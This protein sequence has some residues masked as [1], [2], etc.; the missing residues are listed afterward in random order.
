MGYN[1][2]AARATVP[3]TP[4]V[5]IPALAPAS[6]RSTCSG[7]ALDSTRV[8][9]NQFKWQ[10]AHAVT[11]HRPAHPGDRRPNRPLTWAKL[12][13]KR[14]ANSGPTSPASQSPDDY[15]RFTLVGNDW[16]GLLAWTFA[17]HHP[18]MLDRI[19]L[20]HA[21]VLLPS[22]RSRGVAVRAV[23]VANQA[24]VRFIRVNIFWD[25]GRGAEQRWLERNRPL[26]V[27][28]RLIRLMNQQR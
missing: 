26:T 22:F 14:S 11:Q 9:C 25:C 7:S 27:Q 16:G 5:S 2:T 12:C 20:D 17:L 8:R 23:D 24:F 15:D 1:D 21:D 18:G 3:Q 28:R 6:G 10:R 19:I 4:S 13:S